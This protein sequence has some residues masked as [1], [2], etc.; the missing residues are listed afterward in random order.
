M[1]THE[2]VWNLIYRYLDQTATEEEQAELRHLVVSDPEAA[3][4]FA[5]ATRADNILDGIF[6]EERVIELGKKLEAQY[7]EIRTDDRRDRDSAKQPSA[8]LRRRSSY[9]LGQT[10]SQ[11]LRRPRRS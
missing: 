4:A 7:T 3:E 1:A 2:H 10:S 6:H 5:E 8:R 11:R 9:R